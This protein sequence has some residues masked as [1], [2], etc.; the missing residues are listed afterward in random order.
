MLKFYTSKSKAQRR[1]PLRVNR[2]LHA[3]SEAQVAERKSSSS[4]DELEKPQQWDLL[5]ILLEAD[6]DKYF[7]V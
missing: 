3:E 7:S 5:N 1:K 6:Y 2:H 4:S